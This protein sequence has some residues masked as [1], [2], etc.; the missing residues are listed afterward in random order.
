MIPADRPI[1]RP[2]DARLLAIDARGL[3]H[4]LPRDQFT[5][6]LDEGDLVVAN[7]AATVPASL[8]GIHVPTGRPLEVRL[9]SWRSR[10]GEDVSQFVAIVFGAGDHRTRTENRPLPPPLEPGDRLALGP[11]TAT[12]ADRL[13]HPRLVLLEFDGSPDAIWAGFAHH[14]KPIQYAHLSDRLVLWD[15]WTAIAGVPV[16]FE[17]PSAGFVIDW[18]ALET[19]RAKGVAFSTVTHAAGISSTGDQALDAQLPFDEPYS[20]P[21][22]TARLIA[23]TRQRGGRIIAIGTTVVRALEHA[24]SNDGV[25]RAGVGIA[26]G[27]I[28]AATRLTIVDALLSGTHEPGTSHYELLRA[29][30]DDETLRRADRELE[31]HGYRTHEFGDSIWLSNQHRQHQVTAIEPFEPIEPVP[32]EPIEPTEPFEPLYASPHPSSRETAAGR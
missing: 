3:F 1:Q 32:P 14:G 28:G 6:L 13:G 5:E 25:V 12:I 4:Y 9:A 17:P 30:V 8:D 23:S 15:V 22:A 19:L 20:I 18:H 27:R 26:T 11:L 31:E 16:A 24:A 2:R 21:L 7:D 10:A 29:F